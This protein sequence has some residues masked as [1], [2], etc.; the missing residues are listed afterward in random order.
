MSFEQL[1]RDI[2]YEIFKYLDFKSL[3]NFSKVSHDIFKNAEIKLLQKFWKSGE[4]QKTFE[5]FKFIIVR[6]EMFRLERALE[7]VSIDFNIGKKNLK[8]TTEYS[9]DSTLLNLSP[10]IFSGEK[11][12]KHFKKLSVLRISDWRDAVKI[13]EMFPNFDEL[14]IGF[15]FGYV[16]GEEAHIP[17]PLTVPRIRKIR[18]TCPIPDV[19]HKHFIGVEDLVFFFNYD[20]KLIKHNSATLKYLT[21]LN[22]ESINMNFQISSQ[23]KCFKISTMFSKSSVNKLLENQKELE[24]IFLKG[25][26]VDDAMRNI[27]DVNTNLKIKN[28]YCNGS[29]L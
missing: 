13:F 8:I 24:E 27:L 7:T 5:D 14:E 4:F 29:L 3:L 20:E 1:N 18:T 10:T 6:D 12:T 22:M 15:D 11:Y 21:V 19:F 17:L 25:V 16:P 9:K 26:I 23:L 28:I 2:L